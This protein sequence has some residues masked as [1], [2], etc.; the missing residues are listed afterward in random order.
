M[1]KSASN[2]CWANETL[3]RS[4][5]A[6]TYISSRNGTSRR[7]TFLVA[8]SERPWRRFATSTVSDITVS[9]TRCR[10]SVGGHEFDRVTRSDARLV[11]VLA[12]VHLARGRRDVLR[13]PP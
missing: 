13:P 12:S 10:G 4:R 7:K 8:N 5:N 6:I 2:S 1:P 9:F 3:L 11:H